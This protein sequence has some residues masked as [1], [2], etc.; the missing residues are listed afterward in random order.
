M[1]GNTALWLQ[2]IIQV[3][4]V[5]VSGIED[6]ASHEWAALRGHGQA[7]IARFDVARQASS[8]GQLIRDQ[9]DLLPESRLRIRRNAEA[10]QR[11]ITSVN[12]ALRSI[13]R[14]AG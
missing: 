8:I 10:R 12:T 11:I 3:P 7:L 14:N 1:S 5:I 4:P 9:V 2:G 13:A 6:L